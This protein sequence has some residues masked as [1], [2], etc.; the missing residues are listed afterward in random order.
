M[1]VC[2]L[3]PNDCVTIQMKDA[4]QYFLVGLL[5]VLYKMALT[6]ESQMKGLNRKLLSRSFRRYCF[7]CFVRLIVL[8]RLWMKSS[9]VIVSK[10]A[11]HN[12]K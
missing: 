7:L 6:F 2:G 11:Q 1:K 8:L 12:F 5:I 4:D 9:S 3:N 10:K